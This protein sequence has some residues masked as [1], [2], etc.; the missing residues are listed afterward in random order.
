MQRKHEA[1]EGQVVVEFDGLILMET[2]Q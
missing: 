2:S 1:V